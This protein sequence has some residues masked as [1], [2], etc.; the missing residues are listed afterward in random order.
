MEVS[1]QCNHASLPFRSQ[2]VRSLWAPPLL[3]WIA[4][5]ELPLNG[6]EAL[7]GA[8]AGESPP[9]NFNRAQTHRQQPWP[10]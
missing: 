2:P 3:I 7:A 4:I 1:G 10:L 9:P 5:S 8:G 6:E